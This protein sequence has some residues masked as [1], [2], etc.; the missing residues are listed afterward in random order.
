MRQ[1][2]WEPLI[3]GVYEKGYTLRFA[4]LVLSCL[5]TKTHIGKKQTA[6]TLRTKIDLRQ[7]P[8]PNIN[9]N[10]WI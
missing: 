7:K 5:S 6:S 3:K 1:S 8:G 4:P 10:V 9:G 2:I